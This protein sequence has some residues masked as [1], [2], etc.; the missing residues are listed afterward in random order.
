M[1]SAALELPH[2]RRLDPWVGSAEFPF[3]VLSVVEAT[4]MQLWKNV[5][6]T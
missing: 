5:A 1:L 4:R 2:F 3:A 6:R